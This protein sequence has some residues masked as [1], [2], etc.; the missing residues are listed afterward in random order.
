MGTP[1]TVG[2]VLQAGATANAI[3]A[4]IREDNPGAVVEDRGSY[5][6]VRVPHSCCL[7]RST[8]ERILR[9]PVKFPLDLE[10][11]MPSFTGQLAITPEQVTWSGG[12]P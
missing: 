11:V 10:P 5:L 4:A 7:K 2:P 1:D 8:L 6:R 3:V 12:G 9:R